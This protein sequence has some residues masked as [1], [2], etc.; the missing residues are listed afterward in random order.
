MYLCTWDLC[1]LFGSYPWKG[2]LLSQALL[3]SLSSFSLIPSFDISQT[4]SLSFL[5]LSSLS[6]AVASD[7]DV[8]LLVYEAEGSLHYISLQLFYGQ[9]SNHTPDCP[10]QISVLVRLPPLAL[11][12]GEEGRTLA[13]SSSDGREIG[14]FFAFLVVFWLGMNSIPAYLNDSAATHPFSISVRSDVCPFQ[15]RKCSQISVDPYSLSSEVRYA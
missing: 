7:C 8:A 3:R 11:T 9:C 5:Y 6:P 2:Q 13:C 1:K 4:I 15:Q 12:F 10:G 14:F